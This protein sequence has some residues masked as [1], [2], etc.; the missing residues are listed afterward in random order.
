[1]PKRPL[2]ERL[3]DKPFRLAFYAQAMLYLAVY[4]SGLLSP[5]D[6]NGTPLPISDKLVHFAAHLVLGVSLYLAFRSFGLR[7]PV[8]LALGITAFLA[9]ATE[10]GQHFSPGRQPDLD[11][12]LANLGGLLAAYVV[13]IV[14]RNLARRQTNREKL[15]HN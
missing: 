1:M 13:I 6:L 9:V 8:K 5:I 11:D 14:I 10:A 3:L 7:F 12:F 15:E 4:L 2:I